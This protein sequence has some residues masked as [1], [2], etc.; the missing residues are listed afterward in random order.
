[1]FGS[2]RQVVRASELASA[3]TISNDSHG[4]GERKKERKRSRFRDVDHETR[5]ITK[6]QNKV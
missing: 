1:M 4:R 6:L 5:G 3:N 2:V